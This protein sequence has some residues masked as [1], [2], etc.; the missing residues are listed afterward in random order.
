LYAGTQIGFITADSMPVVKLAEFSFDLLL[1]GFRAA[2]HNRALGEG[3]N[4]RD[5]PEMTLPSGLTLWVSHANPTNALS[6]A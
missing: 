3:S 4:R 1:A 5:G 6:R 2:G